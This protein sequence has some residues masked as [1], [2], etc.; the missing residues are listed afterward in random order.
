MR[1]NTRLL[2]RLTFPNGDQRGWG[3]DYPH[4]PTSEYL[5]TNLEEDFATIPDNTEIRLFYYQ[6][7]E[8]ITAEDG[9][10]LAQKTI[11]WLKSTGDF[12]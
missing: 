2:V 9:V 5:Q 4:Y 6:Y 3:Y 11:D 1:P 7:D 8:V 10:E 12:F